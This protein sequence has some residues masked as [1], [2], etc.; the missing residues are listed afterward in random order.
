MVIILKISKNVVLICLLQL[1]KSTQAEN[2]LFRC[3]W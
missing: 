1:N 3:F 2:E